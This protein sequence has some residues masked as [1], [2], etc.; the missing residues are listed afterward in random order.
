MKQIFLAIVILV[1]CIY[2]GAIGVYI[3]VKYA[4]A[5]QYHEKHYIY[6]NKCLAMYKGAWLPYDCIDSTIESK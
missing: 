2:W 4:Q 3:G 5:N 1:I 6:K